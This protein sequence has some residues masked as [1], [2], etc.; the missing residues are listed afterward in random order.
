MTYQELG[1]ELVALRKSKRLSQ[2]ALADSV[3]VSRATINALEKG[4]S[5]D[6]GIRKVIKILEYFDQ[7]LCFKHK[8]H[9]PTFDELKNEQ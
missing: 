2:Q 6:V 8:T 1:T 5:I 9:F 4:R 7:E 3:G